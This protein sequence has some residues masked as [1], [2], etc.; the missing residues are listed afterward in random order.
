MDRP[1]PPRLALALLVGVAGGLT[2]GL[3]GIAGGAVLVPGLGAALRIGPRAAAA[4]ALVAIIPIAVVG[5]AAYFLAARREVRI[6]LAAVLV[7]GTAAGAPLGAWLARRLPE[8]VLRLGFA[9]L[10]LTLGAEL[11]LRAFI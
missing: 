3:L 2:S 11:L 6:D 5:G 8:A 1:L 9:A 7:L 4:G 10:A